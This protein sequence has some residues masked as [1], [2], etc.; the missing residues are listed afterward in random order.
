MA[1]V[2]CVDM[3]LGG[4]SQAI[5]IGASDISSGFFG[6]NILAVW[7]GLSN[8]IPTIEE[9]VEDL[10]GLPGE[11]GPQALEM[12]VLSHATSQ[13]PIC[14]RLHIFPPYSIIFNECALLCTAISSIFAMS[15]NCNFVC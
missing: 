15:H 1:Q 7:V 14:V 10:P 12:L 8:A 4:T 5:V 6:Y 2:V 9:V 13:M 3:S 11:L